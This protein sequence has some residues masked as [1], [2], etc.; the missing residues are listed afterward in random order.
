MNRPGSA[1]LGVACCLLLASTAWS[2]EVVRRI[3][4]EDILAA[5]ALK[6]GTVIADPG[7]A[8]GRSLRVV[9]EGTMPVTLP[10][11]TI[12]R[13]GIRTARYALRGRVRYEG[14]AVGGY[15][16][17][18]NYLPE[19][20]FFSRSLGESGPMRRLEGSSGWRAFVLPFFN[21]EGGSPP[22]KLLLNLVLAGAGIVEIGPVELVQFAADENPLSDSTAWWSG[23]HAGI[24]GA[25]GGLALGILGA[26]VGW[27][28]SAGRA[29][30]FVL[31][32]L[33]GVA[34]LG[35]GILLLS[36]VAFVGGQPYEV[37]YPL[38]LLGGISAAL[39][40][41]LP[42]SLSKRY[43]DLELRRMQALDA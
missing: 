36:G 39:G 17:M 37:Y 34:W 12:E 19:G 24:L 42:R 10:L 4:W 14:V 11:L 6:S 32:T 8:E 35:I 23:R 1:L 27:L 16:E 20:A 31:K 33:E 28:G 2:E 38:I 7:G 15:L 40:F 13:P 30:G 26:I 9:H 3:K 43:E 41:F 5:N 21:R 25:I 18:W 29:K 22:D